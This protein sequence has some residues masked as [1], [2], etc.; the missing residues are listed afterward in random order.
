M[1]TKSPRPATA[2]RAAPTPRRCRAQSLSRPGP[3]MASVPWRTHRR[4]RVVA[5]RSFLPEGFLGAASVACIGT[6]AFVA[7]RS[8]TDPEKRRQKMASEAGGVEMKSIASY[9]EG[10]GFQRWRRIYDDGAEDVNDV[11]KDIR[12]GHAQTIEKA[13]AWLTTGATESIQGT[14]VCDAGCGT[15]SLTIPLALKGAKVT[16]SDIS[17]AMVSEAQSRFRTSSANGSQADVTEPTFIATDLESLTGKYDVVTCLDV[18]IH[19]PDDKLRD[20][21]GKLSS[22]AEKKLIISF[23]PKTPYYSFLKRVGELF[24]G[25]SKAT[26][27][28]L[29]AEDEVEAMLQQM[30]WI[31]TRRDMTATKFYFSRIL[32][33]VKPT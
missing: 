13:V 24:P 22:L 17:S 4:G 25:P 26:R 27:A 30:G 23:A 33:A 10:E 9:F 6:A 12:D 3:S 21:V 18:V 20:M 16:A 28:Y 5:A 15:G 11:Q 31:I 29:H 14:T 7:L 32:E 2:L 19:Y 8:A 1:T